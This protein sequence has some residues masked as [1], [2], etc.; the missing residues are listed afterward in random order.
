MRR[1]MLNHVEIGC[2][3]RGQYIIFSISLCGQWNAHLKFIRSIDG[4]R[5]GNESYKSG[6]KFPYLSDTVQP[7]FTSNAL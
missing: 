7:I 2:F 6:H 3:I 1:S 5:I 4:C